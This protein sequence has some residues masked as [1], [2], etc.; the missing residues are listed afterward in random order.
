MTYRCYA[1]VSYPH[2]RCELSV[3]GEHYCVY[4]SAGHS[5]PHG[6]ACGYEWQDPETKIIDEYHNH[7]DTCGC[8]R[9]PRGRP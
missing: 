7:T 4:S 3:G 2:T 1:A 9:I 5:K 8:F 6:C